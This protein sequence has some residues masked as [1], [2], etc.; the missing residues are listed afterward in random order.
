M[1]LSDTELQTAYTALTEATRE[2]QL[3]WVLEQVEE[4][5]ALGKTTIKKLPARTY[6]EFALTDLSELEERHRD[7]GGASATF[8]VSEAYSPTERLDLLIDAL[9]I[10]VPTAHH[11]AQQTLTSVREFG[12]VDSML[13]A[14]E[15]LSRQ[16][17]EIRTED[18]D[19]RSPSVSLVENLLNELKA[20]LQ[21]VS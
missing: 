3:G 11:V 18:L 15:V 5:I 8:V 4:R 19:P 6:P 1:A 17:Y 2:C 9:L 12:R 21:D 14:P 16:P 7:K 10:A 20:E 13:F